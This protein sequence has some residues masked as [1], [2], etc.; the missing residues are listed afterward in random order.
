[1]SLKQGSNRGVL[2]ARCAQVNN[3]CIKNAPHKVYYMIY[4]IQK[5]VLHD[6][7]SYNSLYYSWFTHA[8]FLPQW[9]P[10]TQ[11]TQE[12]SMF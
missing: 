6:D 11:V 7:K 2:I 8:V 5:F 4:I 12:N 1:M 3:P 10:P 9:F